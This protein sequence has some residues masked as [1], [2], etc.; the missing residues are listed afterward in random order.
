MSADAAAEADS[1]ETANIHLQM[2]GEECVVEVQIPPG[3]QPVGS[4]LPAARELAH[5]ITGAAV[6]AAQREGRTVSCRAGCGA[7]CRQLVV[8]SLADAQSLAEL[9]A[10][11]PPERQ[12][13]IR[14]RFVDAITRLEAAGLLDSKEA[15]GNRRLV[16]PSSGAPPL[17]YR[18]FQQRIACPFLEDESCS[19]YADRPLV[20]REYLVTSP[21]EDCSR[22]FE[23]PIA[24]VE[25]PVRMGGVMVQMTAKVAG[26]PLEAIPL[27]LSLEWSAAH[28]G[29]LDRKANGTALVQQLV[30]EIANEHQR[31]TAES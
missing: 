6:S 17:A 8:I 11:M 10:A 25:V 16:Q 23:L 7:C 30:A 1:P 24:R 2:F 28:A 21:A 26:A 27:V 19:I 9:V 14:Q 4:L 3:E 22:L 12:A 15:R 5:Q 20:C 29:E 31:L 13:V 18:Y